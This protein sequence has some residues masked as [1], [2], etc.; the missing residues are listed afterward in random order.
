MSV[1]YCTFKLVYI[2]LKLHYFTCTV[3]LPTMFTRHL[4]CV[5]NLLV[6]NNTY[7]LFMMHVHVCSGQLSM[8]VHIMT[9][10]RQANDTCILSADII[11]QP[12][13]MKT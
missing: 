5:I 7:N 3:I 8:C 9:S 13:R 4:T 2:T 11:S 6:S 1:A 10:L 12:L